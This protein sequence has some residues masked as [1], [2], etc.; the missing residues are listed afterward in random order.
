M[1][2]PYASPVPVA[3]YG[4]LAALLSIIGLVFMAAF[5]TKGVSAQKN[6]LVELVFAALA[7]FFLGTGSLFLLL[8]A[9]VYV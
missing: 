4:L 1:E 2:F 7:S 6:I 9:G 8:W 5:F 3:S